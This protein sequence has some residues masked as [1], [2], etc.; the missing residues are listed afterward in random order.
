MRIDERS[1]MRLLQCDAYLE[2]AHLALAEG[3]KD[4]A[5]QHLTQARLL[6]E[7][8]GYGRRRPEIERLAAEVE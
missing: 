1:E 7:E 8:I 5:R 6:V 2:Y 4:Q 3:A